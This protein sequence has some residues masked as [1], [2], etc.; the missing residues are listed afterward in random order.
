MINKDTKI[1]GSFSNNPGN[2]GCK[3][4]NKK[5]ASDNINAIYKSFYSN[6]IGKSIQAALTLGFSGFAVSMPFKIE[7]IKFLDEYEEAV[8]EIGACNTVIIKNGKLK[9]YNT[10]WKGVYNYLYTSYLSKS[11]TILGNG[12]FS[13]A[14]Q[15]A[16]KRLDVTTEII[17]RSNWGIIK[18][19]STP[20]F[21][22][23]PA[24]IVTKQ[25]L[26]DARPHTPEGKI[27]ANL[28]A[29]EQYRLYTNKL[30]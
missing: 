15:Y 1:F 30:S 22:A 2:N 8:N 25:Q 19:V 5:F 4:F 9:G 18:N 21:N 12:G 29:V 13:K 10:D 28:Q 16:C 24:D 26:L 11:M 6:D 23:T 14:V 7:I 27:I 3:F 20:I 17:T